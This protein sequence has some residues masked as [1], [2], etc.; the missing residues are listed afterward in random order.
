MLV[1]PFSYNVE[2][3]SNLIAIT[4]GFR[5]GL[6]FWASRDAMK[7]SFR[8]GYQQMVSRIEFRPPMI[9]LEMY[10]DANE[11]L[12]DV[13]VAYSSWKS[14]LGFVKPKVVFERDPVA[15]LAV[16]F[17]SMVCGIKLNNYTLIFLAFAL[18]FALACLLLS[19]SNCIISMKLYK[20]K[21]RYKSKLGS[22]L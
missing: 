20:C 9:N 4:G 8:E 7:R 3:A 17:A 19:C 11:S 22:K 10:S 16:I 13:L 2:K 21:I 14:D 18:L 1:T 5:G 6:D 12:N 15:L